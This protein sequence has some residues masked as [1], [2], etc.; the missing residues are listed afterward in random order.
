ML[1]L[2]PCL[3]IAAMA[4]LLAGLWWRARPI[5]HAPGILV[6]ESPIQQDDSSGSVIY[7][8]DFQLK[9]VARYKL[10]GEILGTKRYHSGI[11]SELVPVDVAVGWARMSDQV[12]LDSLRI[13]MGNRFFFYEW[14]GTPP[15]PRRELE[16]SAANNHVIS[17]NAAV[18]RAVGRL[19]RGQIAEMQGWL[20]DAEGPN[21]FRWPTSRRRDDTGNGACELFLVEAISVSDE[22]AL[23]QPT[24]SL[25]ARP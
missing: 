16:C 13:S 5:Q 9:P 3:F 6:Q 21:G 25:A 14:F 22:A 4:A 17:A 2:K 11:Q 24:S 18:A 20:V 19:R 23:P 10:R 12:V 8:G 15:I 7:Q 1:R